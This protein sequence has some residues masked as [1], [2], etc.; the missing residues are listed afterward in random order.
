MNLGKKSKIFIVVSLTILIIVF[1]IGPISYLVFNGLITKN[2]YSRANQP[3]YYIVPVE[4][5]IADIE[6][7]TQDNVKV[8]YANLEITLPCK[9]IIKR[10]DSELNCIP[11]TAI[12]L[13]KGA[14]KGFMINSPII[15]P[16]KNKDGEGTSFDTYSKM[17]Y[18]TPDQINFF[19]ITK[20]NN[21]KFLL[22]IHKPITEFHLGSIYKFETS[23]VRGFQFFSQYLK[24]EFVLVRI[25]DKND[26]QYELLFFAFSQPEIDYTLASIKVK[27][28]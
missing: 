4:R 3:D 17:L 12:T 21:E 1:V 14:G 28:E 6:N 19:S 20:N 5:K 10:R 7:Q 16:P 13:D 26:H 2:S 23:N 24:K 27:Q 11:V 15:S 18:M 25:F 9:K 22:L 8:N